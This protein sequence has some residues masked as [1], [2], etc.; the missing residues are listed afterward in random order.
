MFWTDEELRQQWLRMAHVNNA[1]PVSGHHHPVNI[2]IRR[3][4]MSRPTYGVKLDET[5]I[6]EGKVKPRRAN[7]LRVER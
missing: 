1:K 4:A 2:I 3:A 5:G 6:Y 7:T